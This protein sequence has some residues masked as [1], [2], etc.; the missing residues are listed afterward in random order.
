VANKARK[1]WKIVARDCLRAVC[2][3]LRNAAKACAP[4]VFFEQWE[5]WRATTA[6]RRIRSARRLPLPGNGADDRGHA[7]AQP[8]EQ[9]LII[10][11]TENSAAQMISQPFVEF[12]PFGW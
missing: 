3:M 4:R 12:L 1:H 2:A 5:T 8:V 9:A 10:V 6:G 7:K 11:V